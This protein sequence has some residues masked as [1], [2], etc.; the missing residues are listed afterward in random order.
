MLLGT[1]IMKVVAAKTIGLCDTTSFSEPVIRCP[2]TSFF[3]LSYFAIS[4]VFPIITCHTTCLSYL[5]YLATPR[6]FSYRSYLAIPRLFIYLALPY[7]LVS[8]PI[9]PCHT[10][11]FHTV[12]YF[13]MFF[14]PHRAICFSHLVIPCYFF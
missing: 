1:M 5:S 6:V 4:R 13:A 10:T 7:H 9:I 14:I 3:Y 2:T 11:C 8:L 12:S